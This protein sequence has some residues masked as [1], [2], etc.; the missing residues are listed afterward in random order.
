[1]EKFI[2]SQ[3]SIFHLQKLE[4]QFRKKYGKRYRLSEE[5]SRME[6]LTESSTSSDIVIQQ[7]FR[8]FCHELDPQLVEELVMRGIV[9]PGATH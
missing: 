3:A 6:L 5:N 8:R 9:K 4:N 1:M 7:Y 2:F